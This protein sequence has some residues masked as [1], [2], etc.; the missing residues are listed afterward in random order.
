MRRMI[1][2]QNVSYHIKGKRI[3]N[4]ISCGIE[5]RKLIAVIGPNGSGKSTL[6]KCIMR[7]MPY[8]GE[9]LVDGKSIPSGFD[10]A[11]Q[12][13]Y[14][15]QTQNI[16]FPHTVF[17]TV[18]MGRRP[19]AP[20]R[21]TQKDIE[22]TEQA[23]FKMGLAELKE[24]PINRLSGGELQKT[25]F[26]RNLT[27]DAKY[28]LLDEPFNNV[29]PFY[30]IAII[31]TLIELKNSKSIV[32]VLHDINLLRFFDEIIMIKNGEIVKDD[33]NCKS[34]EKLYGV[35]FN[36]LDDGKEKYYIPTIS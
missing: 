27:Q 13:S 26:T 23:A 4:S 7:F 3:L 25:F 16:V 35:R 10:L 8:S 19:H 18:L 28:M 12:I 6:L 36:E 11:K 2:I 34:L 15:P 1:K 29:D 24:R 30:Q 9:I 33:F 32:V 22:I 21:Y 31:K 14:F 20:Y 5:E 17:D